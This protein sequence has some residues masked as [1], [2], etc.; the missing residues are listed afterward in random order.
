MT[1]ESNRN[2]IFYSL[3][4]GNP[5]SNFNL[6]IAGSFRAPPRLLLRDLV[7]GGSAKTVS[8]PRH[9]D[10]GGLMERFFMLTTVGYS[11]MFFELF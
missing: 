5:L 7:F 2:T 4:P 10:H 3:A 8:A 9:A 1:V 11:G 6:A